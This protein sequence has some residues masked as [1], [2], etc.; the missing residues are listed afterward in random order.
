MGGPDQPDDG[1]LVPGSVY[2][3]LT[4]EGKLYLFAGPEQEKAFKAE[5]TNYVEPAAEAEEA[6]AESEATT[7]EEALGEQQNGQ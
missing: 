1:K 3:T 6:P 7:D 5:P 2:H 4:Y